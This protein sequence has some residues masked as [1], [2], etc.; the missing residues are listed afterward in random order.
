VANRW[1]LILAS[2]KIGE[3]G[4]EASSPRGFYRQRRERGREDAGPF[5]SAGAPAARWSGW[6]TVRVDIPCSESLTSGSRSGF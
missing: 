4:K 2:K 5:V 3:K 6:T 1:R